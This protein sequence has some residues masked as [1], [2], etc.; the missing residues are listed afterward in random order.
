[1]NMIDLSKIKVTI[2]AHQESNGRWKFAPKG[3]PTFFVEG[4]W[5][6]FSLNTFASKQGAIRAGKREYARFL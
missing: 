3:Y 1:M 4:W 6:N 5:K 2:V